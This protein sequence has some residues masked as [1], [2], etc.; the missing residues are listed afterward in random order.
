MLKINTSVPVIAGRRRKAGFGLE[1]KARVSDG[2]A[3]PCSLRLRIQ[4]PPGRS[5]SFS[6]RDSSLRRKI[7]LAPS[8]LTSSQVQVYTRKRERERTH[9]GRHDWDRADWI[10]TK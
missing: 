5:Y 10:R 4:L 9:H 6:G 8:L 7:V 2:V 3:R 1:S